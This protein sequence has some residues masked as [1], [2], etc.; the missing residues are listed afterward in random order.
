MKKNPV[1]V[2]GVLVLVIIV[3]VGVLSNGNGGNLMKKFSLGSGN[4]STAASRGVPVGQISATSCPR[5]YVV[6]AG[7]TLCLIALKL[8]GDK[9]YYKDIAAANPGMNQDLIRPGQ[10]LCLPR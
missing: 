6:Q 10:I 9:K 1:L 3:A 5:T 7:D 8:Y 4:L 2:G